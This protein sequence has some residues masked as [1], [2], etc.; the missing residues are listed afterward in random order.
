MEKHPFVYKNA[1]CILYHDETAVS[2]KSFI[3]L[4]RIRAG[5]D[6]AGDNV[7]K[8]STRRDDAATATLNN[9][10]RVITKRRMAKEEKR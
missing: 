6:A 2:R 8:F 10:E 9:A 4:R 3:N 1:L 5:A 7:K